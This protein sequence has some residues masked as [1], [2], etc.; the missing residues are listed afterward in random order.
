MFC[1]ALGFL[2]LRGQ[3][4]ELSQEKA[5]MEQAWET[6]RL[7]QKKLLSAQE[8]AAQRASQLDALQAMQK[9]REDAYQRSVIPVRLFDENLW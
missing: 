4:R 7:T 9:E 3:V 2:T 5:D 6:L 1:A 8:L